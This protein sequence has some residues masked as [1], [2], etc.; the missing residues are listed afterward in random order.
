MIMRMDLKIS[1]LLHDSM[2]STFVVFLT[3]LQL[4]GVS[5]PYAVYTP[6]SRMG[7]LSVLWD[8]GWQE[9]RR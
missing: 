5:R 1:F 8:L 2:A 6:L 3:C 7:T 9:V 4:N